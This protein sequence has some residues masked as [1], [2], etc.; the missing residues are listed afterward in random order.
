MANPCEEKQKKINT[1]VFKNTFPKFDIGVW[2][3][4]T[5]KKKSYAH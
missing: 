1:F 5:V 2:M 4:R 3:I